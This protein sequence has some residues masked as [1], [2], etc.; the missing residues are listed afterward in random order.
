VHT[1]RSG[2]LDYSGE[3][4]VFSH[5]PLVNAANKTVH[6]LSSLEKPILLISHKRGVAIVG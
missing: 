6:S 3:F 5:I 1:E 2:E 4:K